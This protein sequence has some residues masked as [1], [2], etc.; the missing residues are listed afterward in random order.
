MRKAMMKP[1]GLSKRTNTEQSVEASEASAGKNN[2]PAE[3]MDRL[4]KGTRA[5][6]SKEDMLKLTNKNYE[7]LPEVRK[8]KEEERKKEEFKLRQQKA[9]EL[10]E[11]RKEQLRSR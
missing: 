5:K 1:S 10:E 9:K 8:R 3:L 7:N 6:V 11:K 2:M 4:A